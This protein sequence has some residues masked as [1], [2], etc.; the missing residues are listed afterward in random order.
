MLLIVVRKFIKFLNR[1]F[2]RNFTCELCIRL[3]RLH[4]VPRKL[5]AVRTHAFALPLTTSSGRLCQNPR[6][7]P[8]SSRFQLAHGESDTRC[9]RL[10][11]SRSPDGFES[12]EV[13]YRWEIFQ[14]LNPNIFNSKNTFKKIKA[15]QE[16]CGEHS[17][18]RGTCLMVG[19]KLLN[20]VN[21]SFYF[22]PRLLLVTL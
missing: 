20:L 19:K 3:W 1:L 8:A 10:W 7:S 6:I 17:A 13:R 9:S 16:C 5:S 12:A 4:T 18:Q 21:S 22:C 14:V 15:H 11:K 2:P